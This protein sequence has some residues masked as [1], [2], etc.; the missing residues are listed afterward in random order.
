MSKTQTTHIEKENSRK[1]LLVLVSD[2]PFFRTNCLILPTAPFLWENSE[3]FLFGKVLKTQT[4]PLLC[5]GGGR[6]FQLC[7]NFY[8]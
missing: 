3:P 4:N 8:D 5:K 7:I 6:G 1:V 2:T